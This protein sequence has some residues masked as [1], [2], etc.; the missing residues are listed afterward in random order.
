MIPVIVRTK[1]EGPSLSRRVYAAIMQSATASMNV[2]NTT[3]IT[4]A[5]IDGHDEQTASLIHEM[6]LVGIHTIPRKHRLRLFKAVLIA[7]D[8]GCPCY[9]DLDA[10]LEVHAW[11]YLHVMA[12]RA[13]LLEALQV[14]SDQALTETWRLMVDS[15]TSLTTFLSRCKPPITRDQVSR[16]NSTRRIVCSLAKAYPRGTG[17]SEV[18]VERGVIHVILDR[19]VHAVSVMYAMLGVS[20]DTTVIT[21]TGAAFFGMIGSH[22]VRRITRRH[23]VPVLTEALEVDEILVSADDGADVQVLVERTQ[24]LLTSFQA[25]MRVTDTEWQDCET[26]DVRFTNEPGFGEGL[27]REWVG[28]LCG[29]MFH[30]SGYFVPCAA[31]PS[32]S[33]PNPELADDPETNVMMEFAGKVLGIAKRL[34]VPTGVHLSRA[35]VSM[36]T[37]QTLRLEDL[38]ELDP[39][40]ANS[41]NAIR[42]MRTE[43]DVDLGAFVSPGMS[44][45]LFPGG[46]LIS[47]LPHDRRVFANLLEECHLRGRNLCCMKSCHWIMR[48]LLAIL[49][50]DFDSDDIFTQVCGMETSIFN[51]TFGGQGLA[52]EIDVTMW[53]Q[54]TNI[55]Q[56]LM[57]VQVGGE[58]VVGDVV[59]CFFATIFDLGAEQRRILLRFWTGTP[60]LPHGGFSALATRL[61][62]IICPMDVAARRLP[63]AHTCVRTLVLP[64]YTQ[65]GDM[66]HALEAC[67]V[68]MDFDDSH[69]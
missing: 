12:G 39:T 40:L 24:L 22:A 62:L 66:R 56:R 37:M 43:D 10:A 44:C 51:A 31:D 54:H 52:Q 47:V 26:I 69:P 48:G 64:A 16:E 1:Y 5:A 23:D 17:V 65:L 35:A 55:D 9:P 15:I 42:Q 68:S 49:S 21:G 2:A 59:K 32:V 28:L 63:S 45:D 36:I 18:F 61:T 27:A 53:Q 38:R 3:T 67:L 11:E 4:T 19:Y 46:G 57:S 41:C 25:V 14:E 33:H 34:G 29:E 7:Q 8:R 58:D 20:D 13:A 30:G 50:S 6:L 60:S